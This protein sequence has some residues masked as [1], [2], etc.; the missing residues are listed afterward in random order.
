MR[1]HDNNNRD[2]IGN[3]LI[4]RKLQQKTSRLATASSSATAL[5]FLNFHFE[6]RIVTIKVSNYN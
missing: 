3:E 2:G 1:T 4:H 6:R 5:Q